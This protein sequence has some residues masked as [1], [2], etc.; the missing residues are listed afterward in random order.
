MIKYRSKSIMK[1]LENIYY[2]HNIFFDFDFLL[3]NLLNEDETEFLIQYPNANKFLV[4][5]FP[6]NLIKIHIY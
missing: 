3:N 1:F 2:Y 6:I 5:Y 4:R